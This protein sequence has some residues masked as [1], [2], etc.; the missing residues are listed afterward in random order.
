[1]TSSACCVTSAADDAAGLAISE[2]LRAQV[3]SLEQ[4]RRNANDGISLA[5]TAE[6]ALDEVSNI[7]VRL[8]ELAVQAA[9][10]TVS[11]ADKDT[12]QQEFSQL[13]D[14]I[15]RIGLATGFADINLLDGSASVVSF[16]VGFGT[17]NTVNQIS[18]SL[19]PALSA[20]R[21]LLK[22]P[23]IERITVVD[24]DPAMTK[25]AKTHEIFLNINE[26][27]LNSERVQVINQDAYQFMRNSKKFYDAIIV[28]LP[29][30]KSVSLSL[31]Y[32][33]GF[34]KMAHKHLKPFGALVTQST[35]PLYS[36]EAFLCIKKSMEAGG[37]SVIPY[38]NSI[39][40]MGDWGWN[41][42]VKQTAMSAEKLKE[43]LLKLEFSGLETRFINQDAMTSM[44]HFGKGVFEGSD[45]I[46]VNTQSNPVILKY[47]RQG[48]WDVY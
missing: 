25:L 40:T 39:P 43:N 13:R 9:N 24:L 30:P 36:P 14:E 23:D 8:R 29:D 44:A 22:Y 48:D 34:Y 31:L 47:Y 26:G 2:R 37:F 33:V 21:E 42:G 38:Q 16:H 20:V 46:E 7:L 18:V 27:S 35:S 1:M 45:E 12:L 32:S 10:G 41:L 19:D 28:D 17:S 5:Q 11:N 4:A 3:R 6:G 15:N